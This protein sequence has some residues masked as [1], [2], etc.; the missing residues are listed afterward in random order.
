MTNPAMTERMNTIRLWLITCACLLTAQCGPVD[1]LNAVTPDKSIASVETVAYASGPRQSL[2]LYTPNTPKDGAPIIVFIYG[3]SWDTGAKEDYKFA[4]EAFTS[5][6]YSVAVPDYRLYPDVV[7]PAFI[8]DV[9]MATAWTAQRFPGRSIALVG[10]SA[11][12]HSALMLAL[13]TPFLKNQGVERCQTIA[14]AVGLSGPYG[15]LPLKREP[16]ITIFPERMTGKD[17][18]I[19][20]VS[21]NS[22]PIFLA[23]GLKDTKVLPANTISLADELQEAG[24]DVTLVPYPDLDHADTV[25]L[26][27]DFFADESSLRG[28]VLGF[29]DQHGSAKAPFC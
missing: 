21:A 2:D 4:A 24:A 6:G 13:E 28:D 25:K 14:A 22:P 16:F 8:E 9:A 26:M 27:A 20:T 5:A 18:P 12:A 3:G 1:V 7:Y 29:L 15:A 23:T 17:A 19:N 11:G 10:H